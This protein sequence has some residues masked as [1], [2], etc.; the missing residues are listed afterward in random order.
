MID[1]DG[2]H[3]SVV[4]FMILVWAVIMVSIALVSSS[5]AIQNTTYQHMSSVPLTQYFYTN[6]S[7]KMQLDICPVM[8]S[9]EKLVF[10]DDSQEISYRYTRPYEYAN[11]EINVYKNNSLVYHDFYYG[12]TSKI[13]TYHIQIYDCGEY[14]VNLTGRYTTCSLKKK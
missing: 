7:L 2:T 11:T 10:P 12:F 3:W 5:T 9:G 1:E 14:K 8:I 6:S 4:I 13:N